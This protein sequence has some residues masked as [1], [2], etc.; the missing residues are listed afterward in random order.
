M[1]QVRIYHQRKNDA[2]V[3]EVES[4]V[5]SGSEY[6]SSSLEKNRPRLDQS[7]GFRS[8]ES[9]ERRGEQ[10]K[11]TNSYLKRQAGE[12]NRKEDQVL[13]TFDL[14]VTSPRKPALDLQEEQCKPKRDQSGPEE[15]HLGDQAL[16]INIDSPKNKV[17]NSWRSGRSSPHFPG[18]IPDSKIARSL[19]IVQRAEGQ[20]RLKS[21]LEISRKEVLGVT[22]KRINNVFSFTPI[23]VTTARLE[24]YNVYPDI[25]AHE[26]RDGMC[27][28]QRGRQR[29]NRSKEPSPTGIEKEKTS[30][31]D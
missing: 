6:Q 12:D 28:D 27:R 19:K 7:Q 18:Q 11:K 17:T 29:D 26:A 22:K 2:G 30:E 15:N 14:E 8:S 9:G 5:S 25:G 13:T 23:P 10:G 20:H 4:S 21:I 16:T 1:D 24:T 31:D 3:I